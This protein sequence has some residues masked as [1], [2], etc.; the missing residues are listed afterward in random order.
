MAHRAASSHS[1]ASSTRSVA[2]VVIAV[3]SRSDQ[4]PVYRKNRPALARSTLPQAVSF[5]LCNVVNDSTQDETSV[6]LTVEYVFLTTLKPGRLVCNNRQHYF[7][8][9]LFGV[10]VLTMFYAVPVMTASV[11][12]V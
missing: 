5:Y 1:S 8:L 11:C 4:K 3:T 2:S 7:A 12:D 6:Q 9:Y 10:F